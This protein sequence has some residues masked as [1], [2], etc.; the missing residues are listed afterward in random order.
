MRKKTDKAIIKNCISEKFRKQIY[1]FICISAGYV[2][3]ESSKEFWKN[4]HFENMRA[5]FLLRFQN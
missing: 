3:P 1:F 5:S 4:S 2:F